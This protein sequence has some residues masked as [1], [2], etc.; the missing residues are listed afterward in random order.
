MR[1]C[2]IGEDE[3][4]SDGIDMVPDLSCNSLLVEFVMLNTAGVDQTRSVDPN[5]GGRG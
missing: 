1:D 3:N 5:L 4:S 2:A